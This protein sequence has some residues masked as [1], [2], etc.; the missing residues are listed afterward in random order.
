LQVLL[1]VWLKIP[2][3]FQLL[4]EFERLE[5]NTPIRDLVELLTAG[6]QEYRKA[7]ISLLKSKK[8]PDFFFRN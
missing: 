2:F 5:P 4:K 8:K 3:F 1:N 7:I 6:L